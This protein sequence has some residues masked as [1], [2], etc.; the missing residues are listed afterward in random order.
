[1]RSALIFA[2]ALVFGAGLGACD[3]AP[4]ADGLPEWSPK[5]HDHSSGSGQAGGGMAARGPRIVAEGGAPKAN[6]NAELVETAWRAQC[7]LCHGAFGRGDGPQGPMTHATN[8]TDPGFQAARTDADLK[9]AIVNGKNKMPKFD[10][11]PEVV[12]GLVARIRKT[13]GM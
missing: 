4:S 12:D 5:D 8:L 9:A 11:P 7:L 2:F 13:K 3:R 10:L 1:M 6:E